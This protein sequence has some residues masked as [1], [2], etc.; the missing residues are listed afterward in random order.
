MEYSER[1]IT[2]FSKRGYLQVRGE[3]NQKGIVAV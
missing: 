1:A 2:G 3:R